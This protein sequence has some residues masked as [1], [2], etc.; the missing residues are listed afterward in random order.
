MSDRGLVRINL[1]PTLGDPALLGLDGLQWPCS[2]LGNLVANRNNCLMSR[3]PVEVGVQV[4][5]CSISSLG[6]EE[7]DHGNEYKVEAGKYCV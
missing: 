6:V 1:L 3:V 5:E 7:V 2:R 4:L